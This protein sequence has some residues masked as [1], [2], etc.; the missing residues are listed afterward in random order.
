MV[1][2]VVVLVFS[3]EIME[4]YLVAWSYTQGTMVVDTVVLVFT[5]EIMVVYLVVW[6]STQGTM[7]V[8]TVVLDSKPGIMVVVLSSIPGTMVVD[9]VEL[10]TTPGEMV[11]DVVVLGSTPETTLMTIRATKHL[12]SYIT[13]PHHTTQDNPPMIIP[14]NK[15][16]IHITLLV[17]QTPQHHQHSNSLPPYRNTLLVMTKV[18]TP[19]WAHTPHQIPVPT[20]P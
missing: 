18:T 17:F 5:Q 16:T 20:P 14:Q 3:Q 2:L 6:S 19:W 4:V 10:R 15:S 1:V 12:P 13:N 8:D 9:I 11:V 7:V